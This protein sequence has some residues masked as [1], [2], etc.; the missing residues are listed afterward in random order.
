MGGLERGGRGTAA[1]LG[2]LLKV[3]LAVEVQE[4][5]GSEKAVG[6]GAGLLAGSDLG[7]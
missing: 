6:E 7:V 1:W 3:V 5:T 4:T 2:S